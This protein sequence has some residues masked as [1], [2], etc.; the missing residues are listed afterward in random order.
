MNTLPRES[1]KHVVVKGGMAKRGDG[2]VR[3]RSALVTGCSLCA[4]IGACLDKA[5]LFF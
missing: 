5:S 1:V 3:V 4:G 2:P